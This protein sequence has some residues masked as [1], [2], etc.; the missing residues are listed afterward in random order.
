MAIK[1]ELNVPS[2]PSYRYDP[3]ITR[4]PLIKIQQDGTNHLYAL[5]GAMPQDRAPLTGVHKAISTFT[6]S[7]TP[8]GNLYS[9]LA[10]LRQN[11]EPSRD[12]PQRSRKLGKE[13]LT[14]LPAQSPALSR[15]SAGARKTPNGPYPCENCC[16]TFAYPQVLYRHQRE[17]HEPDWCIFCGDFKWAR[18]YLL[19]EHLIK[20]HPELDTDAALADVMKARRKVT[21][22][23]RRSTLRQ[24]PSF[25]AE[26]HQQDYSESHAESCHAKVRNVKTGV[27]HPLQVVGATHSHA[28]QHRIWNSKAVEEALSTVWEPEG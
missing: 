15:R 22:T 13:P 2:G 8:P 18:P 19:K 1:E 3:S 23:T 21:M 14:A 6:V 10:T 24:D 17:K 16:K 9:P 5:P 4:S 11:Q 12:L 26:R 20:K 28:M 27:L 7:L 25:T